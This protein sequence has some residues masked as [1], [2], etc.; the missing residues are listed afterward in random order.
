MWLQEAGTPYSLFKMK[1]SIFGPHSI[2]ERIFYMTAT[3]ISASHASDMM[4]N[5]QRT[6][7]CLLNDW[8]TMSFLFPRGEERAEVLENLQNI[9]LKGWEMIT[10]SSVPPLGALPWPN[11]DLGWMQA[12]GKFTLLHSYFE[13]LHFFVKIH[14]LRQGKNPYF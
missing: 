10:L 3:G 8:M 14:S 7:S 11:P 1:S 13:N 6:P 9:S 2:K 12:A 4:P 5:T